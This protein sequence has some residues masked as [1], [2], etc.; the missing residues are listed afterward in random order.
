MVTWKKERGIFGIYILFMVP[1]SSESN[2]VGLSILGLLPI[3]RFMGP[4]NL[5]AGVLPAIQ[6]ALEHLI[7]HPGILKD[8]QLQL[9]FTDTQVQ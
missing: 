5:T 6:L 4:A 9:Q 1:F 8:Y 2:T 7:S 3:S